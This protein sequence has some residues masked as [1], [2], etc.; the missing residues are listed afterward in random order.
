[1]RNW[2]W[3][4][5]PQKGRRFLSQ[6]G[7]N[8]A[9]EKRWFLLTVLSGAV[10]TQICEPFGNQ[11]SGQNTHRSIVTIKRMFTNSSQVCN[12]YFHISLY[13][14]ID[15]SLSEWYVGIKK[16]RLHMIVLSIGLIQMPNGC[17]HMISRW[18]CIRHFTSKPFQLMPAMPAITLI[19]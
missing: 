6:S 2:N 19:S 17:Q 4:T 9:V 18:I 1:M 5:A 16:F 14:W 3:W 13:P 7:K 15:Y 12:D 10:L 8:Y 11:S